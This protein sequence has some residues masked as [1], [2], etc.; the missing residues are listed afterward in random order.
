[1]SRRKA[2]T[3]VE[4]K[5]EFVKSEAMPKKRKTADIHEEGQN[6]EKKENVSVARKIMPKGRGKIDIDKEGQ[7]AKKKKKKVAQLASQIMQK[8]GEG[9]KEENYS[10][11]TAFSRL[12]VVKST[13]PIDLDLLD[14]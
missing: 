5:V 1:M 10:V 2:T 3:Q 12:L 4:K 6:E 13:E 8:M 14:I 9:K 11:R 7:N